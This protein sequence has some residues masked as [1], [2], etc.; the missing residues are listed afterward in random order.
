MK[1]PK[2]PDIKLLKALIDL[3][4]SVKVRSEESI[5]NCTREQI[6][7]ER[8]CLLNTNPLSII[9]YI[10]SSVEILLNLKEEEDKTIKG[11]AV[12]DIEKQESYEEQ[13]QKLEAEA[14]MHIRVLVI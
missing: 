6:E 11:Q 1:I 9:D 8:R 14:R 12:N 7:S 10:R 4:L 2:T 5:K 3:Y 13:I